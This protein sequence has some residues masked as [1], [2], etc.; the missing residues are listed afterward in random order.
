M[1]HTPAIIIPSSQRSELEEFIA[2]AIAPR[3]A[4]RIT[5]V[6]KDYSDADLLNVLKVSNLYSEGKSD[7]NPVGGFVSSGDIATIRIVAEHAESI[8]ADD[9]TLNGFHLLLR[10]LERVGVLQAEADTFPALTQHIGVAQLHYLGTS[11]Y[12]D[13]DALMLFVQ[14]NIERTDEIIRYML[15]HKTQNLALLRGYFCGE[16]PSLHSGML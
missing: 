14:E 16:S 8:R 4:Y 5:K 13:N 10:G 2:Y 12:C 7:S 9:I 3:S 1:P 11:Q 15:D 6:L